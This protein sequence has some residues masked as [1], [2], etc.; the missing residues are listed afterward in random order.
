MSRILSRSKSAFDFFTAVNTNLC[1][2]FGVI[3]DTVN[4]LNN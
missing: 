4:N 2:K 1:G 3:N